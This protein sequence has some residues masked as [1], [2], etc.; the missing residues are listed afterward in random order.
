VKKAENEDTYF[1]RFKRFIERLYE[2]S[3]IY[4]DLVY[5]AR[6]VKMLIY[7]GTGL[8]IIIVVFFGKP[9]GSLEDLVNWMSHTSYGRLIAIFIAFSLMI[10]GVEKLR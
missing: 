4:R 6:I 3:R 5:L 1:R 7:F 2:H 9:M 10:Y 8:S